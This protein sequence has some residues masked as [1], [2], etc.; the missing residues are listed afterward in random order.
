MVEDMRF[1][2]FELGREQY[3]RFLQPTYIMPIEL[4]SR[5]PRIVVRDLHVVPAALKYAGRIMPIRRK[6]PLETP[7]R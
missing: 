1:G 7:R 3:Q 6:K 2:Y 4:V 5:D